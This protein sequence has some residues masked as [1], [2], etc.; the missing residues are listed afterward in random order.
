MITI[1][2]GCTFGLGPQTDFDALEAT[3][4]I[5][6]PLPWWVKEENLTSRTLISDRRLIDSRGMEFVISRVYGDP[7]GH[8]LRMRFEPQGKTTFA[9]LPRLI[10]RDGDLW[11]TGSV[12]GVGRRADGTI[13]VLTMQLHSIGEIIALL[14]TAVVEVY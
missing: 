5:E 4:E 13:N 11:D 14:P 6:R 1:A 3:P 8:G 2:S 9:F 10:I 12:I 7:N